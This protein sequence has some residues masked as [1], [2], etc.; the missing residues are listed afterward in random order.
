MKILDYCGF[1]K[2]IF[3]LMVANMVSEQNQVIYRT[4]WIEQK[5]Q[6]Q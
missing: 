4:N 1:G 5:A 6:E 3:L 2:T